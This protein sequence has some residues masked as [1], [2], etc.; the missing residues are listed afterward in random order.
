ML[1]QLFQRD[2]SLKV[3]EPSSSVTI[4]QVNLNSKIF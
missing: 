4:A 2:G 3:K 1:D